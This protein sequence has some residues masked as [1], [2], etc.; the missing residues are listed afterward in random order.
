[1]HRIDRNGRVQ[2][3]AEVAVVAGSSEA[4]FAVGVAGEVEFRCVP[5][6]RRGR[7]WIASTWRP[8]ARWP[9]NRAVVVSISP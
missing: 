7:L 4:M 6:L 3:Q 5:G 8:A 9:V 1:M 2:K